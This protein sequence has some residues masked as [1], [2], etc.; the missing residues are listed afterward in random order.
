MGLAGGC[1]P[2]ATP[3]C[4]AQLPRPPS[5]LTCHAHL[6]HPPA[7]PTTTTNCYTL[8]PLP[9][10]LWLGR[11]VWLVGVTGGRGR[12]AWQV[13]VAV[14]R[15]RWATPTCQSHLSHLPD[16]PSCH[17]D[18]SYHCC[19]P[20]FIIIFPNNFSSKEQKYTRVWAFPIS[21]V[22]P[23]WLIR[24]VQIN[25]WVKTDLCDRL[26]LHVPPQNSFVEIFKL[27]IQVFLGNRWIFLAKK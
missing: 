5:T 2:P 24:G 6:P 27:L 4:H 20:G 26:V 23:P 25:F 1:G 3:N 14:G 13:D 17:F 19:G 9:F 11:W 12:W 22:M 15:G 16:T 7:T 18:Q 10:L 8:Q 21:S